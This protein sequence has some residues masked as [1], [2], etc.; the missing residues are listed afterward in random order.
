[1]IDSM[2]FVAMSDDESA[3]T[4][5]GDSLW[6]A[7]VKAVLPIVIGECVKCYAEFR[8]GFSQGYADAI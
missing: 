4:I 7:I 5:G 2:E 8:Q 1:M 3:A 6:S